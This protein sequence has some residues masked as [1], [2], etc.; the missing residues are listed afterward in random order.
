MLAQY[1]NPE[2]GSDKQ[3]EKFDQI[4]R[5]VRKLLHLPEARLDVTRATETLTIEN[6]G[7]RLPLESYGTGVH[8]LVILITAVLSIENSICCIEE[9]EIHL[10]PRLQREFIAFITRDTSNE[11][12]ISSH[13]PV[14]IN[15]MQWL[16]QVGIF[17]LWQ[18]DN[19]TDGG[20]M[21]GDDDAL[22]AL[23]DLGVTASDILQS[24]CI[25]WVEGPS[26]RIY[27]NRWLELV[28]PDLIEGQHYSN[29]FYG[30]KLLFH[31]SIMREKI[32]EDL[33]HVLRL[34]QRAIVLMDSDKAKSQERL[35]KTKKR[36]RAECENSGG[37]CW[38]TS[39][40]EIENYLPEHAI[41]SVCKELTERQISL[42]IHRYNKF[43][44]D[45]R[46]ALSNAKARQLDYSADK[47]RYAKLFT[48]QFV[49]DDIKSDLKTQ[50]ETIA[51]KI[52][53]WNG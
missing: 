40:R 18:K 52:R 51:E 46:E 32:P 12:L 9:P 1:Q 24:N 44:D 49:I 21:S 16:D 29:M 34:N 38:V 28:A 25:I 37:I 45:L 6:N 19:A 35:S 43:D 50:I 41:V 15:A 3:R 17:H 23:S 4:E 39:G 31:L 2:I 48:N 20:Q 47:V 26:D 22:R 10:H 13:S 5:F 11:Y 8:E 7:L 33:V 27:L 30:G 14:F 53:L 36:V 42:E